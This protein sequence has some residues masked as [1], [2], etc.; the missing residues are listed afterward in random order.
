MFWV[1]SAK[2]PKLNICI[3]VKIS[4]DPFFFMSRVLIFLFFMLQVYAS[5]LPVSWQ[6][7]EKK[8]K[9]SWLQENTPEQ[10]R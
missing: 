3:W 7:K 4:L 9:N 10:A 2:F 6:K 5:R 1:A 8:K